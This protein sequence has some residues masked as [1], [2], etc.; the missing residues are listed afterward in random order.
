MADFW[1]PHCDPTIDSG[2]RTLL[3]IP[4]VW[5]Q[6]PLELCSCQGALWG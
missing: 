1:I 2:G 5:A 3:R 4:H 6:H